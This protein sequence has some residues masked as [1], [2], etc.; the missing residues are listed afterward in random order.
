MLAADQ[1]FSCSL[2][3]AVLVETSPA[4]CEHK[5]TL[6]LNCTVCKPQLR[7][8]ALVQPLLDLTR[9][10]FRGCFVTAGL[11]WNVKVVFPSG[12]AQRDCSSFPAPRTHRGLVELYLPCPCCFQTLA[13]RDPLFNSVVFK[14]G[15]FASE[16][17]L[18]RL[19]KPVRQSCVC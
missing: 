11:V 12:W 6:G 8:H 17:L 13:Q 5:R 9:S 15:V 3:P 18:Y 1:P 10:L 19:E 14:T 2:R 4:L 16:R 7:L